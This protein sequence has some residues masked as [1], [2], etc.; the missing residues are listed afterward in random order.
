MSMKHFSAPVLPTSVRRWAW[1]LLLAGLSLQQVEAQVQPQKLSTSGR[2]TMYVDASGALWGWGDNYN[3]VLL[4]PDFDDNNPG[5]STVP[6]RMGTANDWV[7]VAAGETFNLAL[8][9]DGSLWGW[10]LNTAGQLGTG[11]SAYVLTTPTRVVGSQVWVAVSVGYQHTVALD[12]TGRLWAWG[13]NYSGELGIGTDGPGSNSGVPMPIGTDTDWVAVSVGSQHTLALKSTG[14]LYAWGANYNG[15]LGNGTTNNCNT[16]TQVGTGTNWSPHFSANYSTSLAIK[17]DGTLWAWGVNYS[18]Q[19]GNDDPAYAAGSPTPIQVD[20]AADWL[21]VSG[22]NNYSAAIKTNHTLWKW[23][24]V[25]P[26][27]PGVGSPLPVQLGTAADWQEVDGDKRAGLLQK[28]S[29]AP[30][31]F[32][33]NNVGQLGDGTTTDQPLPVPVLFAQ[34]ATDLTVSTGS[35]TTPTAIAAGTY[36]NLT[37]AG[38]GYARLDGAVVVNGALTVQTGGALLTN[39]QGLTGTGSFTLAADATL[40]ICDIEGLSAAAGQGAVQLTGTRSYSPRAT[41]LYNYDGTSVAQN[42][43]IQLPDTVRNLSVSSQSALLLSKPLNIERVLWLNRPLVPMHTLT[44]QSTAAGT[45][46]LVHFGGS[47]QGVLTV[48]RYID[49]NRSSTG[50]RQYASPVPGEVLSTLATNGYTPDFSSVWAYNNSANPSMVAPFPTVF[51]YNEG[52][53]ATAISNYSP[54][55]KGWQAIN[56]NGME[57]GKGYSVHAPGTALVDFRGTPDNARVELTNLARTGTDGGWHLLGNPYASPIDWSTMTSG[58][59][60]SLEDMDAAVYV[61]QSS[62]PYSGSYRV[63]QNGIGNPIIPMSSGFF[64]RTTTPGVPGT[65]RFGK[66]NRVM[67]WGAQPAFGRSTAQRP[68]LSLSVRNAAAT[69]ADE[70]TVYAEAGATLGRDAQYDADK[71]ANPSGLNLAV[72][73]PGGQEQAIAGLPAF[74]A[75][76]V[77]PLRLNVPAAGSYELTANALNLPAGLTAYLRDLS[78]GQQTDLSTQPTL[79][80]NLAAGLSTRYALAFAPAGALATASGLSAAQVA[81]FPNPAAKGAGVALAFPV[82]TGQAATAEVR[83]ALGR[84]VLPLQQLPVTG[85]QAAATLPTAGLTPGVYVLRL[86]AGA[87]TLSRRLVIE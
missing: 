33:E 34:P 57:T 12:N 38:T 21:S 42:T 31:G 55:A 9:S 44:L 64:V 71:L 84:V 28:I 69:L 20:S 19:L 85:G 80:L 45:A 61:F 67:T 4:D 50:Y 83:D 86:T 27:N 25:S 6:V 37:I 2:H 43:G 54:F 82:A 81:L 59:G 24:D 70:L 23:G 79:T 22:G 52:R 75:G 8:K 58:T 74:T 49:N 65:V 29:G 14:A 30:W 15:V 10:G 76:T 39:C 17:T 56:S 51:E 72:L 40:G 46:L 5:Q 48:Q 36:N 66:G 62:G 16:P 60:G 3:N 35:E 13:L 73:T 18:G 63:Y 11:S 1:A 32:G 26:W 7:S 47:I 87:T 53:I 78:T 68:Q 77:L 41:Y